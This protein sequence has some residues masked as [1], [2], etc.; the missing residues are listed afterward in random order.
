MRMYLAKAHVLN[1]TAVISQKRWLKIISI[2]LTNNLL[3]I[4]GVT[5][6]PGKT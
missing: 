2:S 6:A 4:L 1:T 3:L 5:T